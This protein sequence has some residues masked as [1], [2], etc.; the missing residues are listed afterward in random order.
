MTELWKTTGV[1]DPKERIK[2]YGVECIGPAGDGITFVAGTWKPGGEYIQKLIVRNVST[3]VK[4]VKYRLPSTRYF[5]LAY[6]EEIVLSPGMFQ[7]LDVVFRPV[8]N[9]PY[10]D[11]IFFKML[12][13]GEVVGGFHVPVRAWISKLEVTVPYGIDFGFCTTHQTTTLTFDLENTGEVDSPFRWEDADPFLISPMNG[14]VGVGKS[15]EITVKLKPEGAHVFMVQ[16]VCIVGEGVHAI[17]PEPKLITRFSAVAKF[18]YLS[19]SER[20]INFGEIL[21]G[22]SPDERPQEVLLRNSSVVPAEFDCTRHD[23]DRDEVFEVYPRKGIVPARGEVT[24]KVKYSALASGCYSSD[25]YTFRT[26]GNSRTSLTCTGLSIPPVIQFRK[27]VALNPSKAASLDAN[28]LIEGPTGAPMNSI[29][30]GEVEVGLVTTRVFFL[31][32]TSGRD[33]VFSIIADENGVF[34]MSPRQ[35]TIPAG[36]EISVKL[37]FSPQ[38]PI[39]FCRRIWILLG[40][41]LP[42]FYDAYGNGFIRAKGEIKEQRPA[43]LRHAHIQSYR[44]RCVSGKGGMSPE[45]L[46]DLYEQLQ[47]RND[48]SERSAPE[49]AHV[50]MKGTVSLSTAALKSPLTR[51]GESSRAAVAVAHELFVED[52]NPNVSLMF[53]C[54][55]Y[56]MM[57]VP[58]ELT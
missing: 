27:Q 16:A 2:R 12:E 26:P 57:Y 28:T 32:N 42:L 29:N 24:I 9:D 21:S 35:G 31:K 53:H 41:A 18:A 33:T 55:V 39:N 4:H 22:S 37:T 56:D 7:E 19:L 30:F 15:V 58:Y 11:T 44:N 43:P 20:T 6:P 50:G 34:Q 48:G 8:H 3:A 49:F 40:E 25:C 13:G 47:D 5:S 52:S 54:Y 46:D 17:I 51:T 1:I 14:V 23:N 36:M 45:Q 10:D 38:L